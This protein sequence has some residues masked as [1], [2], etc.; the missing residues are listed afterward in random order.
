MNKYIIAIVLIAIAIGGYLIYTGQLPIPGLTT[1]A[2]YVGIS[3]S[4]DMQ[5]SSSDIS[6]FNMTTNVETY[7]KVISLISPPANY[8]IKESNRDSFDK[9]SQY[10]ISVH[11]FKSITIAN[12]R[13]GEVY[14]NKLFEFKSGTD[15]K[16][17]ILIIKSIP[18][19]DTLRI[20][21]SVQINVNSFAFTWYRTISTTIFTKVTACTS[22]NPYVT[23]TGTLMYDG[24][25][26]GTNLVPLAIQLQSYQWVSPT[27]SFGQQYAI[28]IYLKYHGTI[29]SDP[30]ILGLTESDIGSTVMVS[31][32]LSKD[33]Y[34]NIYIEVE[35]IAKVEVT[36]Q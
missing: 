35:N 2:T 6:N 15:R 3:F 8:S 12:N 25:P 30:T 10:N 33:S 9:L 31:G 18:D 20:D 34:G 7:R 16:I 26:V 14:F 11:V 21:I 27:M 5:V 22:D 13:I 23:I 1:E 32:Y 29:I 36:I 4:S 28:T 17:E 19:N 24:S